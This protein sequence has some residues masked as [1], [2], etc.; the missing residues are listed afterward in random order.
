MIDN[1]YRMVISMVKLPAAQAL[2]R[3]AL[4]VRYPSF[5]WQTQWV[6][7]G[8]FFL[9][10]P[11]P[12]GGDSPVFL[13]F[14]PQ[15]QMAPSA[16][17]GRTRSSGECQ[18]QKPIGAAA[19]SGLIGSIYDCAL[20]PQRWPETLKN[21][22]H[23]LDFGGASLSVTAMP[24]GKVLLEIMSLPKF[25]AR[26]AKLIELTRTKWG[27]N[28]AEMWGGLDKFRVSPGGADRTFATEKP[29]GVDE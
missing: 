8:C 4:M 9:T 20:D 15:F 14:C 28:A 18:M 6:Q 5:L 12:D 26:W 22:Q 17:L 16:E 11:P 2:E 25:I 1:R 19:L 27:P 29:I 3:A 10:R 23:E 24:S 21:I 13:V 7:L